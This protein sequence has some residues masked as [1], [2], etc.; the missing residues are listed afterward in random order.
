MLGDTNPSG[1]YT[2]QIIDRIPLRV[3]GF[4]LFAILKLKVS[5]LTLHWTPRALSVSTAFCSKL[6]SF[7]DGDLS[8]AGKEWYVLRVRYPFSETKASFGK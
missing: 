6:R 3:A 8:A 7:T 4:S 5:V 2:E 1:S